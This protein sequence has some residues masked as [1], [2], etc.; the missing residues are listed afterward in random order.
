MIFLWWF[1]KLYL[2]L[3]YINLKFKTM[4][5]EVKDLMSDNEMLSHIF[6]GCI[7]REQLMKIKDQYV[8]TKGNE[9]DWKKE[10]VTIPVEMKIG[11]VSVN[12]KQFF[13]SW[14]D[15][16]E[17]MILDKAK[18]LVAEKLGSQ[19]MRDMQQKLYC[20]EQILD[21]WEKEIN[22][23]VKNPFIKQIINN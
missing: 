4:N 8:G 7:P 17:R 22:W 3:Q 6:L 21:S 15:Q 13:D 20:Y 23:E 9:I 11:D 5:V 14:K 19:K 18:E 10:S 16:M 12:P 1:K 2:Y